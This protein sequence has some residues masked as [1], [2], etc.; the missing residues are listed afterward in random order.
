MTHEQFRDCRD[1]LRALRRVARWLQ[2]NVILWAPIVLENEI[3]KGVRDLPEYRLMME[4]KRMVRYQHALR[5]HMGALYRSLQNL[6][7]PTFADDLVL[8]QSDILV[9]EARAEYH[10]A[11]ERFVER[12]GGRG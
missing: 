9:E 12:I 2:K 1:A 10:A 6:E 3:H 8:A 11:R 7:L 4:A 5:Q